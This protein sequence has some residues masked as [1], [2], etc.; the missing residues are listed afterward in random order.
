[1]SRIVMIAAALGL[2]LA[3]LPQTAT[4]QPAGCPPGLAKKSPACVPPGLANRG[5][6]DR[7]DDDR[8]DRDRRYDDLAD[9]YD[10]DDYRVLRTGDAVTVNGR[11]YIVV[12]VGDRVV[13]KRDDDWYR[14]PGTRDDYV[15]VGDSLIRVD[16]RT[17]AAIE[18]VRLADLIL[19]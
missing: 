19:N 13:L 12:R 7:Y 9:R 8:R 11:D 1:M 16:R 17:R 18:I 10:R 2:G 14:L 15:R 6:T 4:A 3:A 5:A